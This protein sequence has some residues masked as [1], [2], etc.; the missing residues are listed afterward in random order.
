MHEKVHTC[1]VYMADK[2]PVRDECDDTMYVHICTI[3]SVCMCMHVLACVSPLV[4]LARLMYVVRFRTQFSLS[5]SLAANAWNDFSVW[6][7]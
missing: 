7:I 3:V 2:G 1:S 5:L 6:L 4:S